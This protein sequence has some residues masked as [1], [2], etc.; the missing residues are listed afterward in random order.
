MSL[1]PAA[2]PRSALLLHV[3]ALLFLVSALPGCVTRTMYVQST[4]PGASVWIDGQ[5]KGTTPYEETFVSYGTRFVELEAPGHARFRD[6]VEL[7]QPW[8]QVPPIDF[9]TDLLIPIPMHSDHRFN[10][11]MTP[12]DPSAGTRDEARAAYERMKDFVSDFRA[13]APA[14]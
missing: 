5:R 4:P 14:P 2:T 1:G 8:W 11:V 9:V 3:A 6:V 12:R 7:E 13:Q 10:F